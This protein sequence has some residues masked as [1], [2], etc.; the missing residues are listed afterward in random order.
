[1]DMKRKFF[2]TPI[3][4]LGMLAGWLWPQTAVGQDKMLMPRFGKHTVTITNDTV[5]VD[6]L[7][8]TDLT[9]NNNNQATENSAACV[10]FK[11][12]DPGKRIVVTFE[13]VDMNAPAFG[14][15]YKAFIKIYD[16]VCND[17]G[18]VWP[19]AYGSVGTTLPA[20]GMDSLSGTRENL[21]Y[22]AGSEEGLSIGFLYKYANRSRGFKATVSCVEDKA[23]EIAEAGSLYN[24]PERLFG[25]TKQANVLSW[26]WI[27]DGLSV[28]D[29]IQSLTFK[30]EDEDGILPAD[31]FRLYASSTAMLSGDPLETTLTTGEDGTYTFHL[32]YPVAR[33][34]HIL[35]LGADLSA[36]AGVMGKRCAVTATGMTTKLHVD[37]WSG[38]KPATTVP[39]IEIP[40]VAL[41]EPGVKT[42]DIQAK[43]LFYDDGGPDGKIALNFE[44]MVVLRPTT[45]GRVIQIDFKKIDLFNTNPDKNDILNIY[46]GGS[47]DIASLDAADLNVR[48]L[49]E[50]TARVRSMAADGSLTVYLKSTTG[51]AKTGFEAE[52]TEYEPAAMQ[53]VAATQYCDTKQT[54]AQGD[55]VLLLGLKVLTDDILTP[56]T[57]D[58]LTLDFSASR[59]VADVTGGTVYYMGKDSV[60][61]E[62]KAVCLGH[63]GLESETA[64]VVLDRPAVTLG[65]GA[66]YIYVKIGLG[67]AVKAGDLVSAYCSAL[68]LGGRLQTLSK[69]D[70]GGIKLDNIWYSKDGT[71]TKAFKTQVGFKPTPYSSYAYAPSASMPSAQV[72]TFVPKGKADDARIITQMDFSAFDLYA[73]S[74][75]QSYSN[76]DIFKVYSGTTPAAANL[77]WEYTGGADAAGPGKIL[78]SQSADGALTVEFQSKASSASYCGKGF[79]ALVSEY[80]PVPIDLVSLTG[81]QADSGGVAKGDERRLLLGMAVRV[82][83]TL[84]HLNWTGATLHWKDNCHTVL[85]KADLYITKTAVFDAAASPVATSTVATGTTTFTGSYALEEGAYWL[86][87]AVD[88]KADAKNGTV[89]DAEWADLKTSQDKVYA[90]EERDPAGA[91]DIRQSYYLQDG[92]NEDVLVDADGVLMF[93]DDGG[94]SANYSAKKWNGKVTFVPPAG[95]VIKMEIKDLMT[96]GAKHTLSVYGSGDTLQANLWG[97]YY[98]SQYTDKMP[99]PT[100]KLQSRTADGKMT[101]QFMTNSTTTAAGWVIEV[102]AVKPAPHRISGLY[103]EARPAGFVGAYSEAVPA[104]DLKMQV[105]GDQGEVVLQSLTFDLTGTTAALGRLDV[106]YAVTDTLLNMAT[107]ESKLFAR[108]ENLPAGTTSV[109]LRGTAMADWEQTYRLFAVYSLG[110]VTPGDK[111]SVSLRAAETTAGTVEVQ[112]ETALHTVTAGVH[113]EYIV[114]T[115]SAAAYPTL[116]K[117]ID[118]LQG[119]VDGSVTIRIEDGTYMESVV[120]PAIPGISEHNPLHI[121]SVSGDAEKVTL[122]ARTYNEYLDYTTLTRNPDKGVL[123]IAGASYVT[124]SDIGFTATNASKFDALVYIYAGAHH[125]TVSGIR[126]VREQATSYSTAFDH[127]QVMG[128][129]ASGS[130]LVNCAYI[131]V[132]NS[133]FEGGAMACEAGGTGAV[134]VV[135][136]PTDCKAKHIAIVGNTFEKQGDRPIYIHDVEDFRIVGNTMR[137]DYVYSS[138]WQGMD[139]Y[140]SGAPAEVTGNVIRAELP[141]GKYAYGIQ[142]R[143]LYGTVENPVKIVNNSIQFVNAYGATRG[144]TFQSGSEMYG[145]TANLYIAHN[146]VLLSSGTAV[147]NSAVIFMDRDALPEAVE[148]TNNLFQNKA[149]GYVYRLQ[150]ADDTTAL[151]WFNNGTFTTGASYGYIGA[152]KTVEDWRLAVP[153]DQDGVVAEAEFLNESMLGLKTLGTFNA[154]KPL[155]W[156]TTDLFGSER[157]ATG[158]TMGAYEFEGDL[159]EAPVMAADYP[160]VVRVSAYTSDIDLKMSQS[161]VFYGLAYEP[162]ATPVADSIVL[163]GRQANAGRMQAATMRLADLQDH[164]RYKACFILENYNGVRSALPVCTQT[165]MTDFRPT[166]PSTFEAV[167]E[168]DYVEPF[169]D[170][171]AAFQGFSVVSAG[172][173]AVGAPQGARRALTLGE[174]EIRILNT[175]TGLNLTGFFYKSKQTAALTMVNAS[176]TSQETLPA[177]AD[178]RYFGLR[179]KGMAHTLRIVATDS[180]W[181]DDFSGSPLTL[182]ISVAYADTVASKGETIVLSAL[183]SG[184]VPDYTYCWKDGAGEVV[185]RTA[186]WSLAVGKTMRYTVEIQ[187]AWGNMAESSVQVVAKGGADIAD[188]EGLLAVSESNWHGE[189]NGTN[190]F[191]S[192]AFRF[193]NNYQAD[194]DSWSGYGYAN[195]SSNAYVPAMGYGNQY[196]NAAGGGAGGSASY[197]LIYSRGNATYVGGETSIQLQ[198]AYVTNNTMLVNAVREGDSWVGAPFGAGDYFKAVFT[199]VAPDGSTTEQEYYLADYRDENPDEHYV[200]TTW[201]WVDLSGLGTIQSLSVSFEGSRSND[202]GQTLPLYMAIDD[203]NGRYRIDT[204]PCAIQTGTER[205]LTFDGV[206]ALEGRGRWQVELLEEVADAS[207]AT[208]TVADADMRIT[209]LN[210][211]KT[212]ALLKARRNGQTSYMRLDITVMEE[213]VPV[214]KPTFTPAGGEVAAGTEVRIVCATGGAVIHYTTDGTTPDEDSPVYMQALTINEAMT[215]KAVAMMDGM[216]PSEVA[217]AVYT[218][219]AVTPEFDASLRSLSVDRG[220]LTPAFDPTVFRY[221]VNVTSTVENITITAVANDAA[222]TVTG[223]GVQSLKPGANSF[224]V[225]VTA[226]DG[227]TTRTYRIVVTR[228]LANEDDLEAS[229]ISVYPNPT[230]GE[231]NVDLAEPAVLELLTPDGRRLLRKEAGAGTTTLTLDKSGFYLLRVSADGRVTV[232][233]VVRR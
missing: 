142:G 198:G 196:K 224:A 13:F 85:D 41:M 156:V 33:G 190:G 36:E 126:G 185:A 82:S 147:A 201:E 56:L 118:A 117:A 153:S 233:R 146:T 30:V 165:F 77:L 213:P 159:D 181:I 80:V 195:L 130:P 60:F 122:T 230:A 228:A 211:G 179:G 100:A 59:P 28:S 164:H 125:V 97:E 220:E 151:D 214:D 83:G 114:G 145:K 108:A 202:Y 79:D 180:L 132:E 90:I 57:V 39:D 96:G 144:M 168:G 95:Y 119:G 26:Y 121:T 149:G 209:G 169:E 17:E 2:M 107:A 194:Y 219:K 131:R 34:R 1:M 76:H 78:R 46:N 99:D 152:D 101:V 189:R 127:V 162:D 217:E 104:L 110:A 42:L 69:P 215:V 160:T 98:K 32:S 225:T 175:D 81:F 87:V 71:Y 161:G 20:G 52:I 208:L 163:Y 37:G 66:N 178:W 212:T 109:T 68:T 73:G 44:G 47:P 88:V 226:A 207:V 222:S 192:G 172:A 8:E 191:Y 174:A 141:A 187:D 67:D 105:D 216:L 138:S 170:G 150:K 18:Y 136:D 14:T 45:P 7:D 154:T 75:Y 51:V 176:A 102:R 103:A 70:L 210:P 128:A 137:T 205:I 115:S 143:P 173:G 171:T 186:D 72:V 62:T 84:G 50:T 22:I 124:L 148:L 111:V 53:F 139:L 86:W 206:F 203:L 112:G 65:E 19:E 15:A 229:M 155:R 218:I 24:L 93:Y 116:Q 94:P 27:G 129:S 167:T 140:R 61:D 204:Y 134:T 16:G 25:G 40:Y 188:F 157:P 120:I 3:C 123:N 48:L 54:G 106:Y 4:L 49:K 12:A 9:G 232:K 21:T 227:V 5:L 223:V 135:K 29:S 231:L 11:A 74:S 58:A 43:T 31:S 158:A 63:F 38:F 193:D 55:S 197:G 89:I 64:T 113:G 6:F 10:Q 177:S 35:S 166:E 221:T 23:V 184:G 200:L 182:G 183:A 133:Y 199:G 91:L 92:K